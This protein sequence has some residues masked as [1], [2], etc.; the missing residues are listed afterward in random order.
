MNEIETPTY[1]LAV[2]ALPSSSCH[3]KGRKFVAC[4]WR[5]Q[6]CCGLQRYCSCWAF[7]SWTSLSSRPA[8]RLHRHLYRQRHHRSSKPYTVDGARAESGWRLRLW[9]AIISETT[10]RAVSEQPERRKGLPMPKVKYI[11]SPKEIPAGQKYVLVIYGEE[12]ARTRHP[13]GLTITVASAASQLSNSID[14]KVSRTS[15]SPARPKPSRV[16]NYWIDLLGCPQS[17]MGY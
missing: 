7:R 14:P 6:P 2:Q 9:G 16:S 13:L 10:N 11:A 17:G 12:Y 4:D 1:M 15:H 3:A 5:K 8:A